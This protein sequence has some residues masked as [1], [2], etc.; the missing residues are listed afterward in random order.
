VESLAS[1]LFLEMQKLI[2]KLHFLFIFPVVKKIDSSDWHVDVQTDLLKGYAA[3]RLYCE[4]L[5]LPV[6]DGVQTTLLQSA[7]ILPEISPGSCYEHTI[8]EEH[9]ENF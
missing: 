1:A 7:S 4:K 6:L 5:F 8:L 3:T 9:G 2:K